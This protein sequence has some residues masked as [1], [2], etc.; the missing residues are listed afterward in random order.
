M[1]TAAKKVSIPT[2]VERVECLMAELKDALDALAAE[3]KAHIDKNGPE[4]GSMP[5]S[6]FR[7]MIDAKGFGDCLCR[8]YLVAKEEDNK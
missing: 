6:V 4:G 5:Q 1:K 3:R 8:S 7:R 2:L